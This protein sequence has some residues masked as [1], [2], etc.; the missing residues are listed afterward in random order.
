MGHSDFI[1]Y[2]FFGGRKFFAIV[3]HILQT[4]EPTT[5]LMIRYTGK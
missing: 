1:D 3:T 4:A 2:I 5:R